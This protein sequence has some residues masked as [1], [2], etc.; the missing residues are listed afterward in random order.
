MTTHIIVTRWKDGD[1]DSLILKGTYA[2]T[3]AEAM[4]YFD[5]APTGEEEKWTQDRFDR[6]KEFQS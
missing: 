6:L 3:L 4:R 1:S 2:E 5:N